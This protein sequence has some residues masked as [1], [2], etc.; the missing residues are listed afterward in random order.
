M[1]FSKKV[2]DEIIHNLFEYDCAKALLVSFINS[3]YTV[4]LKESG[5]YIRLSSQLS[6]TIR[7]IYTLLKKSGL[8]NILLFIDESLNNPMKKLSYHID[9]SNEEYSKNFTSKNINFFSEITQ[10]DSCKESFLIG[11]F[12]AHGSVNSPETSFYH[13][14]I[15]TNKSDHAIFLMS[16]L[17]HFRIKSNVIEKGGKFKVYV[18]KSES[19]SDVLKLMGAQNSMFEYENVRMVR[20]ISNQVSRLNVID[21]ANMKKISKASN[22]QIALIKRYRDLPNY[23]NFPVKHKA[24][25]EY[26]LKFPE[27]SLSEIAKTIQ[28]KEK[29]KISKSNV[30]HIIRKIKEELSSL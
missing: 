1:T 14:E 7:F 9:I 29:M 26:R 17:S 12:L 30:N 2:K 21:L 20:D 10:D 27:R 25:C 8:K 23:K 16:L 4:I 19:I 13:M 24:F 6:S 5:T 22:E 11:A 28:Q 3:D 15:T 18:K